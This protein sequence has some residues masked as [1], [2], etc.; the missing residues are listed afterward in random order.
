MKRFL[1]SLMVGG[2]VFGTVFAA[3][4][5]LGVSAPTIQAGSDDVLE[6]DTNGVDVEVGW[7]WSD[8]AGAYVATGFIVTDIDPDCDG[9]TISLT[10]T[11]S[12]GDEIETM[13]LGGI[14]TGA[15]L[16][17]SGTITVEELE[18]IHVL[19]SA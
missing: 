8:S 1:V 9:G 13:V 11:D 16:T 14:G 4:A 3:A 19:I 18:G 17:P 2:V 12:N 15:T 6:C 10:A 5:A 7:E